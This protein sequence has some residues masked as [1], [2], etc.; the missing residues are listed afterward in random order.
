[1]NI[2]LKNFIRAQHKH[3]RVCVDIPSVVLEFHPLQRKLRPQLSLIEKCEHIT[4][5]MLL[6]PNT[7]LYDLP[8]LPARI[9]F[10]R[11]VPRIP[12][13]SPFHK[14]HPNRSQNSLLQKFKKHNQ[15]ENDHRR[16]QTRH[17]AIHIQKMYSWTCHI[18][19]I[20]NTRSPETLQRPLKK[21]RLV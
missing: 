19:A 5:V 18:R 17:R 10:H 1:M 11:A 2:S 15:R 7:I 6:S 3:V 8:L 21:T 20:R 9:Q 16:S 14:S 12:R 4:K 13:L